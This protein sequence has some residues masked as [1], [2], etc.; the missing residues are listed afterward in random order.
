MAP[1]LVGT[2][3]H[4][5]DRAPH[6]GFVDV[7][8]IGTGVRGWAVDLANPLQP[9]RL[10]LCLGQS[11]V[12]ETLATADREDIS[13]MLGQ[14]VCSGF[15][16]EGAVMLTLPDFLDDTGDVLAVRVADTG[17][18]L[19]MSGTPPNAAD[20]IAWLRVETVPPAARPEAD[21]ETLMIALQADAAALLLAPLR[22]LP[23]ALQGYIETVAVDAAGYVWFMGWMKRGHLQ[24]FSAVVV[25]RRKSPAAVAVMS[26]TRDDLPGDACGIVGLIASDWRPSSASSDVHLFFGNGGR[27]HL[28]PHLPLRLL[29][30]GE[31]VGEYEGIRERCLGDGRTNT[32]QR[33]LTAMETWLPARTGAQWYAAETSIDRV[34]LVPGL[35]CLVEGWVISPMKRVEGLRLR[36]GGSIMSADPDALYW[37]PRPDLLAAF[38]GSERMVGRAGFVGLFTGCA[39]PDDFA[40]PMLKVVFQ[41]GSSA[42]WPVPAKV[43]RRLG[44]SAAIEDAL[45]FFPALQDEAFFPRFATSAIRAER[46]AMNPPV[47]I[48][49]TPSR[50]TMVFVL[51][52]DRSDVFLLFEEVAAQCRRQAAR[53]RT[54]PPDAA[55]DTTDDI[56][57][58]A[59]V[60]AARSNRSDALW[61]F[62]EFQAAYGA[63]HGIACSLL[64]VDDA[65]HA[66]DLLPDILRELGTNRF[67]FAADGVFLQ[68]TGWA[69]AQQALASDG[70][71]LVFFGIEPDAFE[72]RNPADAAS[73]RCFAWSAGPFARWALDAPAF[74]GG[75]YKDNALLRSGTTQIVHQNAVRSTRT[76]PPTRIQ[77]A[78]NKAIYAQ[79]SQRRPGRAWAREKAARLSPTPVLGVHA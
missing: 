29:T 48:E 39:E 18:Y 4:S 53:K 79:L 63:P 6:R 23:E 44:H 41:G 9:L 11:V 76:L 19:A 57:A 16:F 64:V 15:A 58:L 14:P 37:K 73:A 42:N 49:I 47:V 72:R 52:Q 62:R 45:L 56:K 60:A 1:P 12:A 74:M 50:R 40:D 17:R 10:E 61:L 27:F 59:F 30:A 24:E 33:M 34:L 66:F 2:D 75:F 32:L 5:T 67:F 43:F 77:D 20:I 31:L 51:P 8:D 70:S 25:E 35:G 68:E 46:G 28:S 21:L 55:R 36:V 26:Y 78:V 71:D 54:Q 22:P 65:A 13:A 3:L 38:P 69:R 7:M